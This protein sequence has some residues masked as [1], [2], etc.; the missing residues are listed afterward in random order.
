VSRLPAKRAIRFGVAFVLALAVE[1]CLGQLSATRAAD[2]RVATFSADIT[3]PIGHACMGGGVADAKEVLD[4]LFARGFVLLGAEQPIVVV[5]L[6]WCQCNNDSFDRWRDGLAKAAA[7]TRGRVMLATVHQHDAPICDLTAQRLLDQQG[8]AGYNCDP[9]F[10]EQ[11]VQ[12]TATALKAALAHARRVTHFGIGQAKV[13]Q[14][15]SNRRVTNADGKITWERGSYSGDIFG[16]PEGEIDPWLKTLSFWD[17]DEAVLC[18]SSYAV[19]PMSTYGGGKVSADFPGLARARR[20]EDDPQVFQIYFTGCAGDTTAGKYNTHTPEFRQN[21]ADRLYQGMVAAWKATRR[22]PLGQIDFR[23]AELTLPPRDNG[24]F[25]I[26]AM[27]QALADGKLGRWQRI[28]AAL[29][30]SWRQRV[31][32]GEP[33]DM[34]CLDLNGGAAQF[35]VMPAETFVGYQLAAQSLRPNSYVMVSGFGD[36]APG[37]IPTADCWRDGYDDAYCW[38]DRTV[39]RPMIEA[40]KQAL[41]LSPLAVKERH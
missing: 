12:K 7:T 16:A 36:G 8:L 22:Q 13:E 23:V 24:S 1:Y 29:G 17:G 20:Q 26:P 40:M 5:A 28:S 35:L 39:E 11:A 34:P 38:V 14:V 30:L 19:H 27:Q 21:L 18:W 37:Y 41:G 4:P 9:H 32:E 2:Y 15:A 6:D 25:T 10:H 33:I 3:I 31:A